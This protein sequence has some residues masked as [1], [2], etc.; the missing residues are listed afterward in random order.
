MVAEQRPNNNY[1]LV[2][3]KHEMNDYEKDLTKYSKRYSIYFA[4]QLEIIQGYGIWYL[5]FSPLE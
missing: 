3:N 5:Y 4:V 1:S 2:L